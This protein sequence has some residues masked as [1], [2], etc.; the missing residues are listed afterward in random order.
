MSSAISFLKLGPFFRA[1]Q[2]RETI[3]NG[4]DHDFNFKQKV[5]GKLE[6]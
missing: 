6:H 5:K 2:K 1:S 3:F 4:T